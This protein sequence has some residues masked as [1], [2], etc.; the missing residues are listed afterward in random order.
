M[1]VADHAL[2]AP[3]GLALTMS[4]A[5]SLLLQL[6]AAEPPKSE[7]QLEGDA[8]HW[9]ARTWAQ[10]THLD[11]GAVFTHGGKPWTVDLD[12]VTGSKLWAGE[13][14]VSGRFEDPVA[15]PRIHPQCNG[16]PDWWLYTH[17]PET[18][19]VLDVKD[20]KYGHRYVDPWENWQLIAYALGVAARIGLIYNDTP[21]VLTI[22]QPRAYHRDGPVK[23]WATT[24]GELILLAK[25]AAARVLEALSPDAAATTGPHCID[26]KARHLCKTL[27]YSAMHVVE[28]TGVGE[29]IELP[30][31]ALG[32]EARILFEAHELLGARLEGLKTQAEAILRSG[33]QVP[34]WIMEPGRSL[35]KWNEGVSLEDIRL[36]GLA[37]EA[38][39]IQTPKPVTPTQAKAAGVDE[40]VIKLYA[41]RLPSG[42]T[43]KPDTTIHAS[44]VFAK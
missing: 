5:A 38:D 43:L 6:M 39:T 27:Q 14:G 30:N 3:S 40:A 7:E 33:G 37:A 41:T 36:L 34:Y 8:A 4:C 16:T 24:L 31:A 35:M 1:S 11:V 13:C 17:P 19:G 21:V 15:V 28:F 29:A 9:H 20:Y 26:C 23:R 22:V 42:M 10:G 2:V 18:L 44:K 32:A 12:M 25:R